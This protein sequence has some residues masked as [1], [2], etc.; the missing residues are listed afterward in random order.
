MDLPKTWTLSANAAMQA[1]AEE[2]TDPDMRSPQHSA[3][4]HHAHLCCN[5]A[6][7]IRNHDHLPTTAQAHQTHAWARGP[8]RGSSKWRTEELT[9]DTRQP[10]ECSSLQRKPV[11][12]STTFAARI[13]SPGPDRGCSCS[14]SASGDR[15]H[16]SLP[17][18]LSK[19]WWDVF[20]LE[21]CSARSQVHEAHSARG[22]W[23]VVPAGWGGP[24]RTDDE[25]GS[26]TGVRRAR[27][28][29]RGRPPVQPPAALPLEAAVCQDVRRREGAVLLLEGAAMMR[30]VALSRQSMHPLGMTGRDL[31]CWLWIAAP[32]GH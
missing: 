22:C 7:F 18:R 9:F 11:L 21:E 15:R 24:P 30:S 12:E 16:S 17:D 2:S 8:T 23:A 27:R 14:A 25:Q 31:L 1:H 28:R 29:C 10:M 3:A 13:S 32:V 19:A 4:R 26:G 5:R 6:H 20:G